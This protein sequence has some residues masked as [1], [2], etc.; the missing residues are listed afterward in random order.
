MS[1]GK[2]NT[3]PQKKFLKKTIDKLLKISYNNY[4]KLRKA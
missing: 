4:R 1:R 3:K 2:G